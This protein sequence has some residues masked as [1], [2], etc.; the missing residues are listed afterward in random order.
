MMALIISLWRAFWG[1]LEGPKS[2]GMPT[3]PSLPES[4][5]PPTILTTETATAPTAASHNTVV[6]PSTGDPPHYQEP[7]PTCR[8]WLEFASD[9]GKI[10]E[11]G[12]KIDPETGWYA[13]L[14]IDTPDIVSL[15]RNGLYVTEK[16]MDVA[17]NHTVWKECDR[18][19]MK[20]YHR[21]YTLKGANYSGSLIVRAVDMED[22][23]KFRI[24]DLS[25]DKVVTA[26]AEAGEE[27]LVY[28]W[29]LLHTVKSNNILDDMPLEGLWP[30]PRRE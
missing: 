9:R 30:W 18:F 29:S 6:S 24:K 1:L 13:E 25:H 11:L 8:I 20:M 17:R 28:L 5:L 10:L 19:K 4:P 22:T 21:S 15:M 3:E 27:C 7:P 26:M 16:D 12:G 23:I 2:P 14:I